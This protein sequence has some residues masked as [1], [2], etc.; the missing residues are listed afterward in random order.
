[1]AKQWIVR[2]APGWHG[3]PIDPIVAE[4]DKE[5]EAR[6]HAGDCVCIPGNGWMRWMRWLYLEDGDGRKVAVEPTLVCAECGNRIPLAAAHCLSHPNHE[7]PES[8]EPHTLTWG[9]EA[10][11]EE[12]CSG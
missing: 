5:E 4:Y 11:W 2:K 7:C 6:A 10:C 8:M 9:C 3:E 12:A 1:M